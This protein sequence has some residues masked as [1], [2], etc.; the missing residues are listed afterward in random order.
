MQFSLERC[1]RIPGVRISIR[2]MKIEKIGNMEMHRTEHMTLKE[3]ISK[4]K[5]QQK[6]A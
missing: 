5:Q 6:N 3:F 4:A 1:F 2:S